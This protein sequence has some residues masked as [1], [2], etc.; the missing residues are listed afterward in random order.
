[1]ERDG[2]E[3]GD[4]LSSTSTRLL[5]VMMRGRIPQEAAHFFFVNK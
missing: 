2:C 1:M 5:L 4:W 3:V